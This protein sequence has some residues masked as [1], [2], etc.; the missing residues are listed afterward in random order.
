MS[1]RR[2][3]SSDKTRKIIKTINITSSTQI[4]PMAFW[5]ASDNGSAYMGLM[6]VG[7][8][9]GGGG[10]T[11]QAGGAGGGGCGGEVTIVEDITVINNVPAFI[12]IG[13]GGAGGNHAAN[14]SN[15]GETTFAYNNIT[16]KARGGWGGY[17]PSSDAEMS[18][19]PRLGDAGYGG[20]GGGYKEAINVER[21]YNTKFA[22]PLNPRTWSVKG[23]E[24][25]KNPFDKTDNTVYSSGGGA[26]YNCYDGYDLSSTYPN[27]GGTGAGRGGYGANNASTN[28]GTDATSYGCGGGGGAFSS[29]HGYSQGGNGYQGIVRIY[30]YKYV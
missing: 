5:N 27:Y 19:R 2:E 20:A 21:F 13:T 23:E 25:V 7:G 9:G 30:F 8:G 29:G 24:G 4:P 22:I 1:S 10:D 3:Y 6:I 12:T 15:G 17:N 18:N 26:G 11:Y 28:K 14:G 16:Y